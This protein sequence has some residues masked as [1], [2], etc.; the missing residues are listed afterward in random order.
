LF[1]DSTRESF[2]TKISASDKTTTS[3]LSS[4]ANFNPKFLLADRLNKSDP[5]SAAIISQFGKLSLYH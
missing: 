5:E 1:I 2:D 4:K 3:E